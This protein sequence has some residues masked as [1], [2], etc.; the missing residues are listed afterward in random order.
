MMPNPSRV[1][2]ID[3]ELPHL[4]GLADSLERL[5][6]PCRRVHYTGSLDEIMPCP[7]VRLVIADLHLG[8]GMFADD[9]TTDY[10]I[11][12]SL[13]EDKIR[14][15]GPYSILLWT[16]Y[17]DHADGLQAFL[18]RLRDVSEPVAVTALAKSAHLDCDGNITDERELNRR[19]DELGRWLGPPER[20]GWRWLAHGEN[21]TMRKSTPSSRR[22]MRRDGRGIDQP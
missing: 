6:V 9:P 7:D 22:S 16:R 13:L 17:P 5:G 11:L 1:I 10:S 3:D 15:S 12:G 21:L 18:R 14:P 19:I 2:V 20:R 4:T 8:S